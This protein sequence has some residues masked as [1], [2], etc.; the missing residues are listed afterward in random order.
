MSDINRGNSVWFALNALMASRSR[1]LGIFDDGI[2]QSFKLHH[3]S[4]RYMANRRID[5]IDHRT[6]IEIHLHDALFP[7][8]SFC[9]NLP[10]DFFLRSGCLRH[11]IKRIEK[12]HEF[13][14]AGGG[15]LLFLNRN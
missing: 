5:Q 1:L 14:V 15:N 8:V 6:A 12:P 9:F 4:C 7:G 13:D 3:G 11:V 10:F 2:T